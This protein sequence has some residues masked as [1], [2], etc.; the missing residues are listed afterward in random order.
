M[1]KIKI[2]SKELIELNGGETLNLPKYVPQLINLANQNAQGTRPR[3][4]GQLSELF[5]A[6]LSETT[7]PTIDAWKRWYTERYP[8]AIDTATDKIYA[9]LENLKSAIELINRD[10]VKQWVMDL[11]IEKT[12]SGM[13]YQKAI[14]K[15]IA[16]I[17][18]K[19]YRLSTPDEES[20]G[21][22][23]FIG[24][25]PV[26]IKPITYNFMGRLNEVIDVKIIKY[27]EKKYGINVY[28]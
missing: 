9:G 7:H 13:Y 18:G 4:V 20:V 17:E 1:P 3:V 25:K 22:D 28:Y 26:S 5:P 24:N 23:G 19:S 15:R 10:M 2:T 14:I 27:E 11:V 21:I 12:F 16:E 6:F 8:D